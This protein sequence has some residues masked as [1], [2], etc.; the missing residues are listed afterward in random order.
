MRIALL[1]YFTLQ[2]ALAAQGQDFRA[3][4]IFGDHMVL[5]ASTAAPMHG[6]GPAGAEVVVT[7]SW[8]A[9]VRTKVD[10]DGRWTLK[11]QT[12]ARGEAGELELTCGGQQQKRRGH[13]HPT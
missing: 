2:A 3:A 1:T 11:L 13:H 4:G 12:P 8:G 10:A 5:P 6:F 9:E 7:P